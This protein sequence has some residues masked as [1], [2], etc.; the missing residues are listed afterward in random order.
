LGNAEFAG[1]FGRAAC[2]VDCAI[3]SRG[4]AHVDLPS[5]RQVLDY[6]L[7]SKD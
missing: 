7:F 6:S 5:P 2:R 4:I 3:E 1:I